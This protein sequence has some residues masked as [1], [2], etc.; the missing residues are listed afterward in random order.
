MNDLGGTLINENISRA[1]GADHGQE[2][3]QDQFIDI[4]SSENKTP[5]LRNTLYTEFSNLENVKQF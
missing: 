1:S 4:I 2:T 3:T 5:Y